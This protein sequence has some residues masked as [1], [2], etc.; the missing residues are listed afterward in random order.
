MGV[1]CDLNRKEYKKKENEK[2]TN[3]ETNTYDLNKKEY[4]KKENEKYSNHSTNNCDLNRKEYKK[5]QNEK[6][7]NHSTNTCDLNKKEYKKKQNEKS[8]NHSTKIPLNIVNQVNKSICKITY[9][10]NEDNTHITGF[11]MIIKNIKYLLANYHVINKDLIDKIIYIEIYNNKKIE[12]KINNNDR[13]IKFYEPLDITIIEMKE[14]DNIIKDIDFLDYDPNYIKGYEQYRNK[15]AFVLQYTNKGIAFATGKIEDIINNYEFRHNINTEYGSSGSP[16]ILL[17]TLKVIGIHKKGD[18]Y[19]PVN[20]GLF[21]GEIFKNNILNNKE[22]NNNYIIDNYIIGEIYISEENTGKEIRIINSYEEQS[23]KYEDSIKE[24]Y[25]NEKE[26]EECTIEINDIKYSFSYFHKFEKLGKYKI[27]YI[28]KNLITNCIYM[29]SNCSSITNLNLS[30]FNTQNVT[31]MNFMF[32][33][34]SS[35]TNINLSNFNTQNVK[36]MSFMFYECSSL[37]NLDLSN[38][39]TQ[40]VKDMSFMFWNCSSLT[41][42]NLSNFNTQNVINMRRMLWNCSS[43]TNLNISNFNTQNVIN[44]GSMFWNCS[45]LTNL[46]ISNFNTQNVTNMDSMFWNCSSLTNLNLSNFN[47]QDVTNMDSMFWNCS[48]LTNLNLSNFNTQNV[49]NMDSMFSK[50]SSLTNLNLSNFNTQNVTNMD[51]MFLFCLNLKDVITKDSRI[52]KELNKK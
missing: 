3:Q 2:C 38:F 34:C 32:S 46:N 18:K 16:I 5:K 51:S 42:L 27:K 30:N 35:L 17:N 24:E 36:D 15:D 6:Y 13:D 12:M 49:T 28:F 8:T 4:K 14:T 1:T 19:E 45:S 52:L 29:F 43:L 22:N 26:I 25:R 9:K 50:C 31:N 39:N 44:M 21:I 10:I 40:N 47:T 48:S 11:F 37:I 23:R 7:S 20:Y 33:N 41:K